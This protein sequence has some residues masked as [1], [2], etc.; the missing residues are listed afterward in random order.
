MPQHSE[1]EIAQRRATVA[2][3]YLQGWYQSKIA[4]RVGVTQQQISDDLKSIREG[5][6]NST[7]FDFNEA[8]MREAAKIDALEATYWEAWF[9]SLEP[10]KKKTNRMRGNVDK[11]KSPDKQKVDSF[12]QTEVVEERL[13]DPRYLDG[14]EKCI[15]RR[16]DLFGLDAPL[17]IAETDPNGKAIE[18]RTWLIKDYTAGHRV[19]DP[20]EDLN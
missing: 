13:G 5:W 4:E 17:K 20:D 11:R 1:D 8:K 16:C 12:D 15:R 3:L 2:R 7:I 19:P 18:K 6:R 10:I 9:K 14:V